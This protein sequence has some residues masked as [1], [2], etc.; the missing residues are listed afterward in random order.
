M[1]PMEEYLQALNQ[2]GGQV[3][4]DAAKRFSE[5]LGGVTPQY[6]GAKDYASL[7]QF[8][9]QQFGNIGGVT[10]FVPPDEGGGYFRYDAPAHL[11]YNPSMGFGGVSDRNNPI[12][13]TSLTPT[14]FA[15]ATRVNEYGAD[16]PTAGA[17]TGYS[18]ALT[19]PYFRDGVRGQY[20]ATYDASGKMVDSP[21]WR[22][23]PDDES[24]FDRFLEKYGLLLPLAMVAPYAIPQ[25]LSAAGIG[26]GA[27]A[28]GM[29][30]AEAAVAALAS[31]PEF[32]AA[33]TL[34]SAG[35]GAAGVGAAGLTAAEAAAAALANAPEFAA[36]GTLGSSTEAAIA[37]LANAP[38][39][40]AANTFS[41]P[42]W[43]EPFAQGF[44]SIKDL[45]DVGKFIDG[46]SWLQQGATS[47]FRNVLGQAALTGDVDLERALQAAATAGVTGFADPYIPKEFQP[48]AKA[49]LQGGSAEDIFKG[50]VGNAILGPINETVAGIAGP[51]AAKVATSAVR[52]LLSSGAVNTDKLTVN[53]L[54]D[55]VGSAVAKETGDAFLG[56]AAATAIRNKG[57][58][59]ATIKQLAMGAL[60]T[61]TKKG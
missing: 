59:E 28:G 29:T 13:I 22:D 17:P 1:T 36:A 20:E 38:E 35:A 30:A 52:G 19:T 3:D 54:G 46:P 24:G 48:I 56:K 18:A 44:Q 58:L 61:P 31:A 40:A 39:F 21:K 53:M 27:A 51:T 5:T 33:G 25:M 16:E 4:V 37:A 7:E 9:A 47:G 34:G 10:K 12:G 15:E 2:R 11:Q 32:A 41:N 55:F 45:T 43:Y 49:A 42:S 8:L 26:A 50:A 57:D 23:V 60:T 6:T 14:G